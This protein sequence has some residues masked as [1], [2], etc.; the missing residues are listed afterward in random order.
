MDGGGCCCHAPFPSV[1]PATRQLSARAAPGCTRG[2]HTQLQPAPCSSRGQLART[3]ALVREHSSGAPCATSEALPALYCVIL[4]VS[5]FLHLGDLQKVRVVFGAF[6]WG[7][8]EPGVEPTRV[9]QG[10]WACAG[11][12]RVGKLHRHADSTSRAE[13]RLTMVK[14]ALHHAIGQ[15]CKM[16]G[17]TEF[18]LLLSYSF[19]ARASQHTASTAASLAG[20]SYRSRHLSDG[21][22][23]LLSLEA[24]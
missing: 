23:P 2:W 24:R 12:T 14:T 8:N 13:A 6:T 21:S 5:C 18:L 11:L 1:P 22:A 7:R 9:L 16:T 3:A 17:K 20:M 4:K 19:H 10:S 15:G